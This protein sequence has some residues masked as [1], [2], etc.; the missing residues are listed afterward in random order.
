MVLI[1]PAIVSFFI[2]I[3]TYDH[4]LICNLRYRWKSNDNNQL[5]EKIFIIWK[6][7]NENNKA[8]V[9]DFHRRLSTVIV[10]GQQ[11]RHHSKSDGFH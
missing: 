11:L 2:I 3:V 1:F 6:E 4:W 5:C 10:F 7:I 9:L 8:K